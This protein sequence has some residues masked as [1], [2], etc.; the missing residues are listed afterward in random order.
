[1]YLA[2]PG[3]QLILAIVGQGLLFLQQGRVFISSVSSL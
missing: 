1:M 3:V 2:S